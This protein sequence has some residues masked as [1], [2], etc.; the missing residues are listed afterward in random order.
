M[1]K[2]ITPETVLSYN[3]A[4]SEFL[5]EL[6]DNIY[7]IRFGSFRMRDME[8]N[9]VLFEIERDFEETTEDSRLIQY[10]FEI[11][12]GSISGRIVFVWLM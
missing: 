2:N 10:F 11:I 4:T 6:S 8:N 12:F 5:C 1:I 7:D 9:R 3:Q